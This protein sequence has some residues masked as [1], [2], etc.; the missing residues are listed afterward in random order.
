[1]V[2]I[3]TNGEMAL[4]HNGMTYVCSA[5]AGPAFE[6][7][8]ISCGMRGG[9]GAIDSVVIGETVQISTINGRRP[10]G[11]CGSGLVDAVAQMLDAGIIDASG[12]LLSA[13]EAKSV[14]EFVRSRLI[15]TEAGTEFVLAAK[16]ESGTG[17]A[18]T[19]TH[20]DIRQLQLAKGSIRAAIA[21]LMRIAGASESDLS[22][23]LLAGAFGNY[24]RVES[25]IRIGLIPEVAREKVV[26]IGNAAG[27]GSRLALL[28]EQ[29]MNRAR[30][31]ARSAQHVELAVSPDYQMELM[32]RMMFPEPVKPQ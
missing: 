30:R 22:E 7:A 26:S 25:A 4:L 13:D 17:R 9:P 29:E 32:D 10:I 19:L 16:K 20:A 12:R 27:A 8:G 1:A 24:I 28:C 5:A 21:T 14:G 2:D 11:I 15:E 6:G 3:G 18:I 23:V 31:L